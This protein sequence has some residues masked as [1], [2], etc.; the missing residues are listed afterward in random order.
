MKVNFKHGKEI[1]KELDQTPI[2]MGVG[3]TLEILGVTYR[4]IKEEV[5]LKGPRI[6]ERNYIIVP[7]NSKEFINATPTE[8]VKLNPIIKVEEEKHTKYFILHKE[9]INGE[10]TNWKKFRN[11]D[12]E[13]EERDLFFQSLLKDNHTDKKF[14]R[15]N[16][17]PDG[18]K[19]NLKEVKAPKIKK[20]KTEAISKDSPI[21]EEVEKMFSEGKNKKE[22]LTQL[23]N[24]GLS[25]K[26]LT[27]YLK[28]VVSPVYINNFFKSSN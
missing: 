12:D 8:V 1:L 28:G 23:K 2:N 7:Y 19:I 27:K 16:E 20:N 14:K 11:F 25:K 6:L 18:Q 17:E 10:W 24:N 21:K 4:V 5:K 26:D 3:K 22:V 15:M 9:I 13:E